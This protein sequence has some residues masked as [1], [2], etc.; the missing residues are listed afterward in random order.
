MRVLTHLI[1][2]VLKLA[3]SRLKSLSEI[4]GKSLNFG[5]SVNVCLAALRVYILYTEREITHG[6]KRLT[7]SNSALFA[8]SHSYNLENTSSLG[9]RGQGVGP[10]KREGGG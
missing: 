3:N 9:G 6:M 8:E 1:C 5:R 10:S 2:I 4:R 7:L